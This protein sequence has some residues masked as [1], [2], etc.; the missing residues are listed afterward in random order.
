MTRAMD[1]DIGPAPSRGSVD[2]ADFDDFDDPG[3]PRGKG[4]LYAI[5]AMLVLIGAAIIAVLMLRPDVIAKITGNAPVDDPEPPTP[6]AIVHRPPGGTL[7]VRGPEDAQILLYLGRGPAT[8]EH[9]P[10]GVAHEVVVVSDSAA[11]RSVVPADARWE[12]IADG[13]DDQTPQPQDSQRYELAVQVPTS[14]RGVLSVGASQLSPD[15]MGT[16]TGELG[17][18]RIV[19]NPPGAKV[20]L[21]IGFT[22]AQVEDLRVDAAHE[23]LVATEEREPLRLVIGPSDWIQQPDG[24]HTAEVDARRE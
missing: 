8:A 12:A 6:E 14:E 24:A 19:T 3:A 7:S 2:L 9:L 21:L 11:N 13:G 20:Y 10:V 5:L 15:S 16:P 1:D 17:T 22:E 4:G 23:V 18:V